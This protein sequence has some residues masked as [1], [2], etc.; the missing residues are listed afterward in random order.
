M[1]PIVK[2]FQD[3]FSKNSL[4][5]RQVILICYSIIVLALSWFTYFN[6]YDKPPALFWDEN[7]HIVAAQRYL[8]GIAFMEY[9]PPLAKLFIAAGEY[10]L[11][12]NKEINP[13]QLHQL[14]KNDYTKKVPA[15]YSF[16]GVRFFPTLLAW[17]SAIV[18]FYIFYLISKNPHTALLFSSLYIFENALIV[19]SRSAM[20]DSTL[21]F[22]AFLTILY[23]VLLIN[24]KTPVSW[25]NYLALGILAGLAFMAKYNGGIVFLT[26]PFLWWYE[27][28]FKKLTAD[29][30]RLA[31]DFMAKALAFSLG[32]LLV[33]VL[34]W[35]IHFALGKKIE[36]NE[37]PYIF[38]EQYKTIINQGKQWNIFN[39][40]IMLKDNIIYSIKYNKGV[41][42]L[43][44]CKPGEN[45]SYPLVWPFGDK[46]I[47]Y[48]W[49]KY[50]NGQAVKYLYL[51]SN[52][53]IWF[54]G[55]LALIL[56]ISLLI[57]K[58]VFGSQVKAPKLFFLIAF[59]T[60]LYLCYMAVMVKMTRVMY[61]YHYFIPLLFTL[62][63]VYLQFHY[64]FSDLLKNKPMFIYLVV[65][66][67]VILV[68]ASYIFFSPLTYYQPLTTKQFESRAWFHFW[69]LTPIK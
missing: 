49:E 24:K 48:R 62:I 31:I 12:P 22:F 34:V 59:F 65:T 39:F 21:L 44:I 16:K 38:S 53:V 19:H 61:L 35:Q 69:H 2:K 42:K 23:F 47:N 32:I 27:F 52:P 5:K 30:K 66:L 64:L 14:T 40:P 11:R 18:F 26:F 43:D 17:L 4:L 41:P 57:A 55:L 29:K 13:Q 37:N 8:E 50:G 36:N 28:K 20:L 46:A 33:V 68:I 1:F 3:V 63:L 7:Y 54:S 58:F 15:G 67:F 51:Q 25:K 6:N 56:S 10:L 9:H 60:I 45:G